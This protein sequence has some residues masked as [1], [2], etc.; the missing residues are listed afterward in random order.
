MS[1]MTTA[2]MDLTILSNEAL[3][4]LANA[5]GLAGDIEGEELCLVEMLRRNHFPVAW[6]DE[7]TEMAG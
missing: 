7:L 2:T 1:P 3:E 6:L 5:F 4:R